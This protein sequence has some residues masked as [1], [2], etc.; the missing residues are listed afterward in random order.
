MNDLIQRNLE[1]LSTSY[2]PTAM[3]LRAMASP[4]QGEPLESLTVLDA[5]L[6][7]IDTAFSS[8]GRTDATL[9]E[10]QDVLRETASIL[11]IGETDDDVA[12]VPPD[13]LEFRLYVLKHTVWSSLL[14]IL[15]HLHDLND[16]DPASYQGIRRAV[17]VSSSHEGYMFYK[18]LGGE[19]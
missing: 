12:D 6:G 3:V 11:L 14:R 19:Q 13:V 1:Y 15:V 17:Q 10:M 18:S 7:G 5:F 2:G 4:E 8:K 16:R 9:A